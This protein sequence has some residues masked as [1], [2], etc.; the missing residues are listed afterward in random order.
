MKREKGKVPEKRFWRQNFGWSP[1]VLH[2]CQ[3][4]AIRTKLEALNTKL[5]PK[6]QAAEKPKAL[7]RWI[8]TDTPLFKMELQSLALLC[9]AVGLSDSVAQ[10]ASPTVARKLLPSPSDEEDGSC[11]RA[12]KH[13]LPSALLLVLLMKLLG[14]VTLTQHHLKKWRED[15]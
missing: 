3:I 15:H 14:E 5:R 4:C 11:Q 13:R 1:G 8:M 12:R 6:V 2:K 9:P 7:M 10:L